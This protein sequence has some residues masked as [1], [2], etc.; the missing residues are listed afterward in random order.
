MTTSTTRIHYTFTDNNGV[1]KRSYVSS[2]IPVKVS[3][4][5]AI[6]IVKR[7]GIGLNPTFRKITII[8]K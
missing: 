1:E 6:E 8:T 3:V 7:M 4:K 5:D 2:M